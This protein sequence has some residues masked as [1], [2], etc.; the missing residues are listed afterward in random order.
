M[1]TTSLAAVLELVDQLSEQEQEQVTE[2]L[3][4]KK[5]ADFTASSDEQPDQAELKKRFAEWLEDLEQIETQNP[6]DVSSYKQEYV[7]GLVE[8][9]RRQGLKL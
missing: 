5:Y 1:M 8:K 6:I 3:L 9:Y 4:A 7:E 2:Y